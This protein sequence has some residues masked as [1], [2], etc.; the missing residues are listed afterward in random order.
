MGAEQIATVV[1]VFACYFWWWVALSALRRAHFQYANSN[2]Q[3]DKYESPLLNEHA[4][5]NSGSNKKIGYDNKDPR[6]QYQELQGYGKRAKNTMDN[7]QEQFAFFAAAAIM[8]LVLRENNMTDKS[9][10]A[11]AALS[12]I[13]AAMRGLHMVFYIGDWDMFRST[14]FGIGKLSLFALYGLAIA[15]AV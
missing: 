2:Q 4:S 3:G 10:K 11:V 15:A 12:V 9:G 8:N 5:Q 7:H 13:Y 1:S 6:R 14:V